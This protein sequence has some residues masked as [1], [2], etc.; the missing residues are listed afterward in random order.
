M[1]RYF[2]NEFTARI[3]TSTIAKVRP[4]FVIL[5]MALSPGFVLL[6]RIETPLIL[7]T[8]TPCLPI[9]SIVTMYSSPTL[10]GVLGA[11][12]P[13]KR[14]SSASSIQINRNQS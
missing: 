3:N 9:S 1:P 12:A 7:A 13:P 6:T 11:F 14:D 2:E 5:T 8:P 4:T 10:I